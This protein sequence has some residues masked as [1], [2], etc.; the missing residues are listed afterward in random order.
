MGNKGKDCKTLVRFPLSNTI[1]IRIPELEASERGT[2]QYL[3]IYE[4]TK[5]IKPDS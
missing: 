5:L 3:R 1:V 2:K 4:F